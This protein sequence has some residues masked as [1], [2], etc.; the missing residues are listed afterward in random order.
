M[1]LLGGMDDY[2]EGNMAW[3]EFTDF[4]FVVSLVLIFVCIVATLFVC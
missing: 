2:V 3:S 4:L 1:N